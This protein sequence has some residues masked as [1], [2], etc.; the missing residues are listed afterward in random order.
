MIDIA[1]VIVEYWRERN[2]I[3]V[4]EETGQIVIYKKGIYVPF[5]DAKIKN[6]INAYL[7]DPLENEAKDEDFLDV[8]FTTTLLHQVK[9][10]LHSQIAKLN[11][12]DRFE[13]RVNCLNGLIDLRDGSFRD[14]I[15]F[16]ETP[17]KSLI[18]IPINYDK[19]A[20][21]PIINKFLIEVFGADRI[22]FIYEIL[23]YLLYRSNKLQKAFIFFGEASSGKTSF[24]E[25]IRIFLGP[26][27]IQDISI[28]KINQRF[29][30]GNLRNK[31][32]NIYDDL[33]IKKIGYIQNFK[34]IVTNK[35]LT[36]E[37]KGIQD[38][39]TWNNF[40]KQIYTCNNLP[41]VGE[42]MG[43]DFW[44]RII[45][46]HCTNFF[47]NG[48]KDFN[49]VDK[50]TT[51]EELSGLLNCCVFHFKHLLARKHFVDRF[52]NIETVKGIWQINISPLKL[53]LDTNCSLI[54][55][56]R[57]EVHH[58]RS[59]VNAFRKDKNAMPISQNLITRRLKDLG[60]TQT[61]KGP[62]GNQKKYYIGIKLNKTII[63]DEMDILDRYF[64]KEENVKKGKILDTFGDEIKF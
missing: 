43:D 32:A 21:C 62:K 10:R 3:L 11:D 63:G 1:K 9:N 50:I 19:E 24:I 36:S 48:T 39:V 6:W 33:P 61:K 60:I 40:C 30:M 4:I 41:E 15:N 28:Q 29:Q 20:L 16:D 31:M 38:L 49:I 25:M 59:Q 12:F 7:N 56:E 45:L 8:K 13:W 34:Q 52:D 46:I 23:A 18:Q 2:S 35:T 5:L 42:N 44:R 57:E 26:K 47:D 51:P 54:E 58:F 17:Y 37:L 14:H 22:A 64:E 55:N 53:F 27:N